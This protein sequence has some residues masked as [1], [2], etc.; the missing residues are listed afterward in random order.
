V[1]KLLGRNDV[2]DA[3][4]KLDT[5]TIEEARMAITENLNVTHSVENKVTVLIES[6]QEALKV[7]KRVDNKVSI[8]IDGGQD[9]FSLVIHALLNMDTARCERNKCSHTAVSRRRR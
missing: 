4:K 1:R 5:L 3:L 6:G 9:A 2:E 8:L 7:T